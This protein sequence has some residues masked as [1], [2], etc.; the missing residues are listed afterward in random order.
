MG[1]QK[2]GYVID[3]GGEKHFAGKVLPLPKETKE[4][5]TVEPEKDQRTARVKDKLVKVGILQAIE[6]RLKKA[7]KSYA[8]MI[9][10]GARLHKEP[11]LSR[12]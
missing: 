9:S 11:L 12:W 4:D 5:T 10:E 6:A 1:A 2:G 3:K 7:G 8:R